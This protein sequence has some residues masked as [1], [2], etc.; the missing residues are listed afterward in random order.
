MGGLPGACPMSR[1]VDAKSPEDG[2]AVES[3]VVGVACSTLVAVACGE[4]NS[5]CYL[6]DIS[7][8]ESPK[9]VKVFNLTPASETQNPAYAYDQ[10]T[11]GDLDAESTL[12]VTA[13]QSP[14]GKDGIIFGGAISGTLS[15]WEFECT[16]PVEAVRENVCF[17][18][19]ESLSLVKDSDGLS[20]GAIV[21]IVVGCVVGG[22][23]IGLLTY[24]KKM[25][26]V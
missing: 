9:L 23:L 10:G 1:T 20:T 25:G 18:E 8:I 26:V 11:L 17:A 12:F 15:F 6:Y 24:Y 7:A 4:N 3:V 5:N 13:K 16:I 22:V 21:G 14:T 19:E 2:L